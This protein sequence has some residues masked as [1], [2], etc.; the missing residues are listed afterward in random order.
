[1]DFATLKNLRILYV[2]DEGDVRR[3]VKEA[4]APFVKEIIEASNGKE[5]FEIFSSDSQT[6]DLIITDILMPEMS[7]IEMIRKIRTLDREIPVIYTTAFDESNYLRQ[8]IELDAT[9]Y[10]LKPIDIEALVKAIQKASALI[11][12]RLL[13][14]KLQVT[15]LHLEQKVEEKTS[16]LLQQLNTDTLTGLPNRKALRE[17]L[18]GA[19]SSGIILTDIDAF[20]TYNEIYGEEVGNE[21]LKSFAEFLT[22]FAVKRHYQVYRIGGD[23]FALYNTECIEMSLCEK[24][25]Q[26]LLQEVKQKEISL[27]K[28]PLRFRLGLSIGIASG[29][30]KPIEKASMA[31]RRAKITK[32]NLLTYSPEYSFDEEYQHDMY[33]FKKIRQAIEKDQVQMFLQPIVDADENILKYEAL[34]RIVEGDKIHLPGEF[35]DVAKKMKLYSELSRIILSKVFE[36]SRT[37]TCPLSVN[38]TIENIEDEEF[39]R[40]LIENIQLFGVEKLLTFEILESENIR[41]YE[42]VITFMNR[43]QELGCEVAID[44]FGSGYSNFI[45]L[46]KL[47]PDYIKIDGSLIQNIHQSPQA[48]TIVQAINQFSH[49]LGIRTVAEFVCSREVFEKLKTIGV[50]SFQG[51][52]FSKPLPPHALGEGRCPA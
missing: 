48:E 9:A 30:E 37:K 12:N 10:I 33:W 16:Q 8:T 43:M 51:Y 14:N 42:R 25:A 22:A 11:E 31:L 23:I 19:P 47:H 41:D 38:L 21:I 36:I 34:V 3:S 7:G 26:D 44:D 40:W 27:Q 29:T 46:R 6:I 20:R 4:I 15:N 5:G 18:T 39:T 50:D 17:A 45:Y 13:R 52:H 28:Y 49:T 2:E 32:K 24:L 1:M 35:L